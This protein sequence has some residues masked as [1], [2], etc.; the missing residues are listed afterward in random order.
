MRSELVPFLTGTRQTLCSVICLSSPLARFTL[1]SYMPPDFF[2]PIFLD[3]KQD[4]LDH[5]A[6][7]TLHTCIHVYLCVPFSLS[8]LSGSV[9]TYSLTN[10]CH[11]SSLFQSLC[12]DESNL[13][14]IHIAPTLVLNLAFGFLT[15]FLPFLS[16]FLSLSSPR[17]FLFSAF[18]ASRGSR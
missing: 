18:F 17:Y 15:I 1:L 10:R 8:Y 13:R 14:S 4:R 9:F 5:C 6:F 12:S 3:D 2:L 16:Q 11:V 7:S